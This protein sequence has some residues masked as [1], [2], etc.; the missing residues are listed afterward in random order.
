MDAKQHLY[1]ALG[2]LAYAVAKAAGKVQIEEQ[3]LVRKIVNEGTTHE[4]DFTY[5]DIIFQILQKDNMGF[6]EVYQWAMKSFEL[7]KYHFSEKMKTE[8]IDVIT[9]VAEV[10][11]PTNEDEKEMLARFGDDIKKLKVNT[12]ID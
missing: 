8:F 3:E 4:I 6:K 1:Y 12:V 2:S 10:F 9:R 11:P 7:G 5:T